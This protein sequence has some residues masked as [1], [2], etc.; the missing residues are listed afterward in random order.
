MGTAERFEADS[1]E[2]G[3]EWFAAMCR[4]RPCDLARRRKMGCADLVRSIV[5]R[6]GR[7]LRI[8]LGEL[9]RDEGCPGR[10]RRGA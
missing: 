2:I 7:A 3:G 10:A 5:G 1:I 8:G 9:K 6:K 4:R